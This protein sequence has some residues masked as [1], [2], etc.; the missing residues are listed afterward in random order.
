MA[1]GAAIVT[2]R[3]G[4][5]MLTSGAVNSSDAFFAADAEAARQ[6]DQARNADARAGQQSLA[7]QIRY[8]GLFIGV[9]VVSMV[10]GVAVVVRSAKRLD[11]A[12]QEQA[13]LRGLAREAGIRIRANLR[14]DDV[15]REAITTLELDL[16][17]GMVYIHLMTD[18]QL[19]MPQTYQGGPPIGPLRRLARRRAGL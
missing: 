8:D 7:R 17:C 3:A 14:A 2:R 12:A 10:M 15:I 19:G 6:I 11:R 5:A 9:V 1:D 16:G 13:R 18:G 4:N